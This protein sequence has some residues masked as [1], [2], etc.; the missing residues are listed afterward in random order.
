MIFRYITTFFNF[1]FIFLQII[2]KKNH[3]VYY[4]NYDNPLKLVL[5]SKQKCLRLNQIFKNLYVGW[6]Q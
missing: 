6:M 3:L 2:Y 5:F 1:F 4:N